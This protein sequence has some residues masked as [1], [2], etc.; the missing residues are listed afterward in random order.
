M[1]IRETYSEV[2]YKNYSTVVSCSQM[3]EADAA[4]RQRLHEAL[5]EIDA[6]FEAIIIASEQAKD[7]DS[8]KTPRLMSEMFV[9]QDAEEDD[10][11][12]M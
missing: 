5:V 12:D 10:E 8:E 6:K 11:M 1:L 2:M 7:I 3:I 9:A 4:A